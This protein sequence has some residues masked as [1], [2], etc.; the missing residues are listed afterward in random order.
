MG[1]QIKG[2]RKMLLG[3]WN[4]YRFHVPY[5]EGVD[6]IFRILFEFN[7]GVLCLNCRA[8]VPQAIRSK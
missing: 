3:M 6:S 7:V 2:Y 5:S 8:V 1:S 4:F